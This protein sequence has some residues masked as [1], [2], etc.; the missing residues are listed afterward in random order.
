MTRGRFLPHGRGHI[1]EFREKL[2]WSPSDGNAVGS[3]ARAK[4][5]E[6]AGV[7]HVLPQVAEGT[8]SVCSPGRHLLPHR[9]TFRCGSRETPS[10]LG[11]SID[12]LMRVSP[13]VWTRIRSDR[14]L[15]VLGTSHGFH[16]PFA[17]GERSPS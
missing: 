7:F 3:E 17:T 10:Q 9:M 14:V 2:L 4:P 13:F 8:T 15:H 11:V 6:A 1:K 12:G 5:G 16:R